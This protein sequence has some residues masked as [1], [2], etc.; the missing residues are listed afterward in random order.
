[1]GEKKTNNTPLKG[2][3]IK[4]SSTIENTRA[5]WSKYQ[6]ISIT[7][8]INKS[9]EENSK[10]WKDNAGEEEEDGNLTINSNNWFREA[11]SPRWIQ[12][13]K[14]KHNQTNARKLIKNK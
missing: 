12:E 5:K 1:M 4:T 8:E 10:E 13:G 9:N 7:R 2:W 14:I 11:R 3:I 6:T